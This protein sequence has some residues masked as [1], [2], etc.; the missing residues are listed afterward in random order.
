MG[1]AEFYRGPSGRILPGPRVSLEEALKK[2]KNLFQQKK[3]SLAYLF[4]SYA[5]DE[6]GVFS[7]LDIAILLDC[8]GEELYSA[9]RELILEVQRALGT[10]RFDLL[11][12]NSASPPLQFEIICLGQLLYARNEQVLN[13]FEMGTIRRFQD[14]AYLRAVQNDY[15]KKRVRE[16]YSERK[17]F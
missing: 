15:L 6:A 16:W 14:T 8:S 7:D 2:L 3:V 9:Y 13:T 10:E 5:Q 1:V 12:L 17:A 4:G 11:L